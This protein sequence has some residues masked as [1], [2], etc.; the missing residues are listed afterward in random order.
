MKLTYDMLTELC[1]EHIVLLF[2]SNGD[3]GAIFSEGHGNRIHG[4]RMRATE[5]RDIRLHTDS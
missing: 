5:Q 4:R 1:A 2:A 3:Q